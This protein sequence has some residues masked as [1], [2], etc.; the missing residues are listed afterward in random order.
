LLQ[1]NSARLLGTVPQSSLHSLRFVFTRENK[2]SLDQDAAG[3]F[4][5]STISFSS[6]RRSVSPW[7]F[8]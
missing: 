3:F 1:E 2:N 6:H 5:N 7:Y 4:A 8:S